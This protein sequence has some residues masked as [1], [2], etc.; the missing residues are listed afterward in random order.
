[1]AASPTYIIRRDMTLVFRRRVPCLAQRFYRKNFFS[2]SLRT[3]LFSEARRRAAIAAR[4]TD[5]LIGLIEMCGADMLDEK[6]L[7]CMV[8][9]L[10]RFEVA[11]SEA[12]RETCGPRGPEAVS[13]AVRLHEATRETM[14]AA[15]VYNDYEAVSSPLDRTLGRLGVVVEPGSKDWLRAASHAARAL[16]EVADE[17]I[18]REQG[19]YR[20]DT[21]LLSSMSATPDSISQNAPAPMALQ[22]P[23]RPGY[24]KDLD[25]SPQHD[26]Q[27]VASTDHGSALP[28]RIPHV[29]NSAPIEPTQYQEK[30]S[31]GVI[32]DRLHKSHATNPTYA[33]P[34]G[35]REV[36][37]AA[38]SE[39]ILTGESLFSAWFDAAVDRKREENPGWD[40]NNLGNWRST[41]KLFIEAHGD[42][43]MSFYSKDKLLEFRALL[44]AMPKNHHKSSDSPGFYTIIDRAEAEEAGNLIIAE[45]EIVEHKL[46]RGDAEQRRARARVVRVRSA[47]VYRHMQAIQYVFRHAADHGAAPANAMKGVIWTT[48]QL[49]RLK[50]EEKDMR[51]LPWGDKLVD[52]LRTCAFTTPTGPGRD[53]HAVFWPTLIAPHSGMREEEALQLR[54]EDFDTMKGIPIIRVQSGEGQHIKG[55]T[56]YRI[57]PVH[58]NLIELGL[59]TYVQE[60]RSK[61]Q[62]WLFPNIDRCAAKGRLSG[63]FT[64]SFGHYRIQEGVYDPRRDFHSLRTHFN[65][66]LKR[67]KCPLEIRK[68]LLGHKLRDITEEHYDPEGSPI[69][70]YKEWVDSIVSGAPTPHLRHIA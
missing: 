32:A 66:E 5:D 45:N 26:R 4:F 48:K 19:I 44:C 29:A 60:C 23:P 55:G 8:D 35:L 65:V 16:I 42:R 40:T 49:D 63:T 13:A 41:K 7:D 38:D 33:C 53:P 27:P 17:N 39:E 24:A 20:T 30:Q 12:L 61:G 58:K 50:A 21:R 54:T 62:D 14:R 37:V 34:Q 31:D 59:L 15:L 52:L 67:A 3:H 1:M 25:Q 9:D 46:S 18:C 43:A 51:R 69:E 10:M 22:L 36:T 2:F 47:T 68:R 11:A 56:K 6:Q 57:V 70:E 28:C 64:K